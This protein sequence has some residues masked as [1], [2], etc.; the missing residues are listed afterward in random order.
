MNV[1]ININQ[2]NKQLAIKPKKTQINAKNKTKFCLYNFFSINESNICDNIR[3]IPYYFNYYK[4]LIDYDFIQ[5]GQLGEKVLE[6]LENIHITNEKALIFHYNNDE[7]CVKFN[8]FLFNLST[9]KALI[10]HVLES[11]S[12]LLHSL[13]KLNDNNVCFFNLSSENI[14]FDNECGEKPLLQNFNKSLQLSNLNESYIT[15]II[16]K[17]KDYSNK[18]LEVHVLFYL[19]E[20]DLNTIS[21]SFIEEITEV[22]VQNLS[23]LTLF[24]QSYKDNYKTNCT[25]SLKKYINK[26]KSSIIADILEYYDTWDSY[27]LSV[28][29]LHIFGNISRIFSLKGSLISKLSI[30]ISKNIN[31]EPSKR[32]KLNESL[33]KYEELINQFTDWSYIKPIKKEKLQLLYQILSE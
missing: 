17:T 22:F 21:Y 32:E 19:I 12:Y 10:F 16:K 31:P 18:P 9:P 2:I 1:C 30:E 4:I 13:A 24:S 28:I 25:N 7:K 14:V 23:V 26:S 5:I 27:S 20:N 15:N 33:K 29:Y 6:K 8:D 3:K 11:Y